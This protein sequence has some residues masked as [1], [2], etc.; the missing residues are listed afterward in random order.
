MTFKKLVCKNLDCESQSFEI[1]KVSK[2]FLEYKCLICANVTRVHTS[3]CE[4]LIGKK[5]EGNKIK[6]HF[7]INLDLLDEEHDEGNAPGIFE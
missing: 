6:T 2:N 5:F 4:Y 7:Q 1:V 3:H